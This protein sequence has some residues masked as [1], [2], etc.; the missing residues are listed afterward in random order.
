MITI[1]YHKL[2]LNACKMQYNHTEITKLFDMYSHFFVK[3][4]I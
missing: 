2:D 4:F 1:K 3:K